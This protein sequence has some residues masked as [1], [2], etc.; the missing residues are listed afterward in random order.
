MSAF[1]CARLE[2]SVW[3][4]ELSVV[5][6]VSADDVSP[7]LEVELRPRSVRFETVR[8]ENESV[9]PLASIATVTPFDALLPLKIFWPSKSA[10]VKIVLI[11]LSRSVNSVL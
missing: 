7:M 4:A 2:V 6:I 9:V 1:T 3:M 8:L 11:W 10:L 5:I